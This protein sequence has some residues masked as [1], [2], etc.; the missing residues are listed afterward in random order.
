MEAASL[1][2]GTH[3]S[4]PEYRDE[5]KTRYIVYRFNDGEFS[6]LDDTLF[7]LDPAAND[8]AASL[9]FE[10]VPFVLDGHIR[11]ADHIQ[12]QNGYLYVLSSGEL[13]T[14]R[15]EGNSA[16]RTSRIEPMGSWVSSWRAEQALIRYSGDRAM[17]SQRRYLPSGG[18]VVISGFTIG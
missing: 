1:I 17:I 18:M 2:P 3:G 9:A 13:H 7:E 10:Q 15:L 16:I 5:K 4:Y 11:K 8:G 6:R 12:F 14:F